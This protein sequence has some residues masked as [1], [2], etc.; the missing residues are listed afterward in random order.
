[1]GAMAA[2][3]LLLLSLAAAPQQG[4]EPIRL[5]LGAGGRPLG[6]QADGDR[7]LV[8]WA[9]S[10]GAWISRSEDGGRSYLSPVP[11]WMQLPGEVFGAAQPLWDGNRI[12]LMLTHGQIYQT[13]PGILEL[14]WSDDLGLTWSQLTLSQRASDAQLRADGSELVAAW[15]EG[16]HAHQ[17]LLAL[18]SLTG[19]AGLASAVPVMLNEPGRDVD[20]GDYALEVIQGTAFVLY[21]QFDGPLFV[22][23]NTLWF[24]AADFRSGA[25]WQSPLHL[26]DRGCCDR[27]R[28]AAA[29]GW[30]QLTWLAFTGFLPGDPNRLMHRRLDLQSGAFGPEALLAEPV[31]SHALAAESGSVLIAYTELGLEAAVSGDFGATFS[32]ATLLVTGPNS[33]NTLQVFAEGGVLSVA[34]EWTYKAFVQLLS[35]P[36][37]SWSPPIPLSFTD[38]S[39]FDTRFDWSGQG[40]SGCWTAPVGGVPWKPFAG[41]LLLPWVTAEYD[42]VAQL[43]LRMGGIVPA[44]SGPYARWAGSTTLGTQP[45]PEAPGELVHL[46]ASRIYT[47]TTAFPPRLLALVQ[48]DG[49]ATLTVP[50]GRLPGLTVH[51]QGWTNGGC[52]TCGAPAG[53]VFRLVIP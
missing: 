48:P 19:P 22:N 28:L 1:M 23:A 10:T 9:D 2:A 16:P 51:V 29:G 43:T 37:A 40:L 26:Y 6:I 20:P 25:G 11:A 12:Y 47:W 41:G 33:L 53:E 31:R 32:G 52:Q 35:A 27:P 7:V 14:L 24:T 46:G 4:R 8:C 13:E 44:A 30:L 49:S 3:L 38:N 21:C 34:Y 17:D 42:G 45:H 5:D 15:L 36:A 18:T 50:V 39:A